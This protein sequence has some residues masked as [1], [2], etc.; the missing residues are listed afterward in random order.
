MVLYAELTYGTRSSFMGDKPEL[1]IAPSV[2]AHGAE[3][4]LSVCRSRLSPTARRMTDAI[5]AL[6]A[7]VGFL[8]MQYEEQ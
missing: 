4:V 7:D 3:S 6:F 8:A 1:A 5:V 2:D